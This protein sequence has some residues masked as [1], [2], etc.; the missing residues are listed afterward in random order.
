MFILP[1]GKSRTP[2]T[3]KDRGCRT[4]AQ[5][6]AV[7]TFLSEVDFSCGNPF[8]QITP[9]EQYNCTF[10][11]IFYRHGVD[12]VRLAKITPTGRVTFLDATKQEYVNELY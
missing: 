2:V 6:E 10:R 3:I 11:F 9:D 12:Q 5:F 7:Q 1:V 8:E 4:Q